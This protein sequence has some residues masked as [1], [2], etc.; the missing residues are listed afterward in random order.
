MKVSARLQAPGDTVAVTTFV[1]ERSTTCSGDSVY[2]HGGELGC[3][4]ATPADP[5]NVNA[6]AAVSTIDDR[7]MF[8]W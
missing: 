4:V 1:P 3:A 6:A 2:E 8:G 7:I 5:A